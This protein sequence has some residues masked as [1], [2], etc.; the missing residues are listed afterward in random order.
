MYKTY[1][2]IPHILPVNVQPVGVSF[3]KNRYKFYSNA[4]PYENFGQTVWYCVLLYVHFHISLLYVDSLSCFSWPDLTVFL[5]R[6]GN[7]PHSSC[8]VKI[9]KLLFTQVFLNSFGRLSFAYSHLSRTCWT[10]VV[11]TEHIQQPGYPASI[12]QSSHVWTN[13]A[14]TEHIQQLPNISNSYWTYPAA[15][16][17][18][19]QL[20][21]IS[22]SYWYIQQVAA[23]IRQPKH[24]QQLLYLY[25]QQPEHFQKL[26]NVSRLSV[27]TEILCT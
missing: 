17:H 10:A 27:E 16:E 14:A 4:V 2:C 8:S 18:I 1:L 21:N 3:P 24:V 5:A 9:H 23:H 26:L 20:L 11:V 25:I 22:S 12:D 13:P 6:L 15:T 7:F 19:Q